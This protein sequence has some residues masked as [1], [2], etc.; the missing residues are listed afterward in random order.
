M[1]CP[2]EGDYSKSLANPTLENT[3]LLFLNCVL[4]QVQD[5]FLESVSEETNLNKVDM[6]ECIF[7]DCTKLSAAA[8][9]M[10]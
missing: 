10:G 1:F 4:L 8:G 3:N 6:K 2:R 9:V 5:W 7:T